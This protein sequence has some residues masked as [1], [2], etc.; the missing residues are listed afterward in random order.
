LRHKHD[1]VGSIAYST[2]TALTFVVC[3][4]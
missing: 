3:W 2:R 1:E 4:S